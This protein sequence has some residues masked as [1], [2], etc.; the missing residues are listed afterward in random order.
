MSYQ[1][2]IL[3]ILISTLSFGSDF[4]EI[5]FSGISMLP[6]DKFSKDSLL[7][8]LGIE[9][10]PIYKFWQKRPTFEK[11][12]IKEFEENLK[13]YYEA[14]GFYKVRITPVENNQTLLFNID[15][16]EQIR[17]FSIEVNSSADISNKI[18][19]KQ[20]DIF[21]TLDFKAIKNDIERELLIKGYAKAELDAKAFVDL[22]KYQVDLKFKLEK[23]EINKFSSTTIKGLKTIKQELIEDELKYSEGEIFDITKIEESYQNLYNLNAFS[24]ISIEPR[25]D[26]D[27]K[28]IP[29]NIELKEAKARTF[30]GSIGYGTDEGARGS[31]GWSH[32]NF[33]GN[34]KKFEVDLSLNQ[35]GY[36]LSNRFFIPKIKTIFNSSFENLLS[37]NKTTYDGY[38]ETKLSES[39]SL[40][41]EFFGIQNFVGFKMEHSQIETTSSILNKC[42]NL[43]DGNYL[44]NSFFYRAFLDKRDSKLNAKNGY[45]IEFNIDYSDEILGSAI[46][47]IKTTFEA[48]LIKTI[49]NFTLGTKAKIGLISKEV[50]IF[51]RFFTG[52]SYNNRGYEYRTLGDKD[53][54]N[55]P[56][57]GN[58][59][60]D[61]TF[62]LNHPLYK[63][64][65]GAIFFDSSIL[66]KE[67]FKFDANYYHSYGFGVRYNTI[68]GP[69]RVDF[70]FPLD[71]SGFKFHFSIGQVF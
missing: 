37:I 62:E 16:N 17:V 32:K 40:S 11:S 55:N 41:R 26:V 18:T 5:E 47:F 39:L 14:Y 21:E 31:I 20:G 52:G 46:N 53:C 28:E 49:N 42:F 36:G 68:I 9:Y 23:G 57:G 6:T 54:L 43:N 67:A 13:K 8:V 7:K 30:K 25:V 50:P 33:Y 34:L 45:L 3:L 63:D 24:Y 69:I 48:R 12:Q 58:S 56:I 61:L 15:K 64:L 44:I 27:G 1:K 22:E 66:E 19:L 38:I 2:L 65:S 51:K 10:P 59:L 71:D 35:L 60:I 29:I 4:K 70:G